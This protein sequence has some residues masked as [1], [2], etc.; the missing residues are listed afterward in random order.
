VLSK[1]I[2]G[3]DMHYVEHGCGRPLVLVHGSFTDLRFWEMQVAAF[4]QRHRVFSVSMRPYWPNAQ[5]TPVGTFS[6]PQ[7]ADDVAGFIAALDVGPVDLCGHSLGGHVALRV[8]QAVPEL[9]RA[10]VL[11]EPGGP[12]APDL[13]PS[14]GPGLPTSPPPVNPMVEAARLIAANDVDA[15]LSS[16]VAS[17]CRPGAWEVCPE[18]YKTTARDNATTL[19]AQAVE[20]R[21][22]IT[23]ADVQ[24]ITQPVF[25]IGGADSPAPFPTILD[26][27]EANLADV[28]RNR[29]PKGTHLM[30][31]EN[32]T[33]F[34]DTVLAF[35][36]RH[37]AM[38]WSAA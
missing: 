3:F 2:N 31:I 6:V 22:P 19:I 37:A 14:S 38:T 29:I 34:N 13:I 30:N 20:V 5:Q 1:R 36:S 28:Q 9:V 24:S 17:A 25:L 10:L 11:A 7:Y 8:A 18:F 12:L 26:A 16:L 35:L 33:A 27:L 23:L 32:P 4:A 21:P 15:G